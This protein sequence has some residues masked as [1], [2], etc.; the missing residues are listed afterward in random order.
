MKFESLLFVLSV[1]FVVFFLY[2]IWDML[3]FL[4]DRPE[5]DPDTWRRRGVTIF[6]MV[7]LAVILG[8]YVALDCSENLSTE[9]EVAFVVLAY[10]VLLLYRIHKEKR[11]FGRILDL[12]VLKFRYEEAI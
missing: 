5:N 9:V 11:F 8:A 4:K 1:L 6:W 10:L 3:W 7:F 12:L 2:F